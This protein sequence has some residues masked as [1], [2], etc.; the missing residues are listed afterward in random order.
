MEVES[1]LNSRPL[2][3]MSEYVRDL[4]I[5]SSKQFG[6]Q[7]RR[8][9]DKPLISVATNRKVESAFLAAMVQGIST[10]ATATYQV[11]STIWRE[12]MSRSIG[13]GKGR[14]CFAASLA[15]GSSYRGLSRR[16]WY[17]AGSSY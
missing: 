16:R 11:E 17:C 2:T 4:S 10:T 5:F 12:S 13:S 15:N 1:I 6:T 14:R 9:Q 3:P 8:P 7:F